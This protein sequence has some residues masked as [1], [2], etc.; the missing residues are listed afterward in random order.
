MAK[1]ERREKSQPK[2][3]PT[4]SSGASK[5]PRPPPV[6]QPG[7]KGP[8]YLHKKPAR[9]KPSSSSSSSGV[10]G[11]KLQAQALPVEL[12][13]LVLDIFRETFPA[14]WDFEGLKPT[15]Q[16]INAALAERD[17]G[18]AFGTEEFREAYA[19]RWSPSRALC[20]AN[21]LADILSSG[22]CDNPRVTQFLGSVNQGSPSHR[23]VCIG[24][25]VSEMMAFG[26]LLRHLKPEAAGK[27][28]PGT[29]EAS[30]NQDLGSSNKTDDSQDVPPLLHLT[31]VDTA[32]WASVVSKLERGLKT[33]PALSKY[34]SAAA[35]ANNAS[36]IGSETLRVAFTQA[37]VLTSSVE[38]LK[39]LIGPD[40][41]LITLFFTLNDLYT[42]SI[43]KTTKFLVEMSMAA[44]QG[45][46]L[47]VVDSVGASSE[48]RVSKA[49]GAK[50]GGKKYSMAWLMDHLLLDKGKTEGEEG[51]EVGSG[52]PAWEKL[53]GD[54]CR[55]FRL[56][57]GLK[58]PASLENMRFQ[59]H[60]FKRL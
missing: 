42:A 6:Q 16:E 44:P 4:A 52:E 53:L 35:R 55:L 46:L 3:K 31:L 14:S 29:A 60:L 20:F 48:A 28:S 26:A 18:V 17:F 37:D 15:L 5:A 57:E 19:I 25:G 1:F 27:P 58:Y 22:A 23:G 11:P 56:E 45:S 39:A 49:P 36:L 8:T 13:Q 51:E 43:P 2:H 32:D 59:V 50:D 21:L 10:S 33:P 40:A 47:L 9:P 12:L 54:D 7:W 30:N 38:D 41:A 24:A 34:A